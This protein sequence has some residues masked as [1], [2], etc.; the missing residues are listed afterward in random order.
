MQIHHTYSGVIQ[1]NTSLD[2][3]III[4]MLYTYDKNLGNFG[5]LQ[6]I[7]QSFFA[8]FHSFQ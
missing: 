6:A 3:F 5:K 4:F 1:L 7:Y 2:Q 8:N